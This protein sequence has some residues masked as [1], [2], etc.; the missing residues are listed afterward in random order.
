MSIDE[1]RPTIKP[2]T[3]HSL[4]LL[5]YLL[6]SVY[7]II[8]LPLKPSRQTSDPFLNISNTQDPSFFPIHQCCSSALT[9]LYYNC[10]PLLYA[11]CNFNSENMPRGIFSLCLSLGSFTKKCYQVWQIV[12]PKCSWLDE[13]NCTA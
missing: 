9:I 7:F 6:Y 3:W 1:K 2:F 12:K 4:M 13:E 8:F 11:T 5:L 10:I